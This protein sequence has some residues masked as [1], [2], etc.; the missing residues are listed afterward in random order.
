MTDY[1]PTDEQIEALAAAD[2][3]LNSGYSVGDDT[4]A[5]Q[6]WI[7]AERTL[8]ASPA[9]QAIIRAAQQRAWHEGA[10]AGWDASGEGWNNEWAHS[11]SQDS[12]WEGMQ[13]A[14]GSVMPQ[15]PYSDAQDDPTY[16]RD[17]ARDDHAINQW[18]IANDLRDEA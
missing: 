18:E 11:G 16:T 10:K 3:R 15:N 1:Q 13:Q 12:T 14:F 6:S 17:D 8:T 5:P 2:Y 4:T 7:D 9:F